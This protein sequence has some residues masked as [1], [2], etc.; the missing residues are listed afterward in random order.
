MVSPV[1]S[2]ILI[3]VGVVMLIGVGVLAAVC[4]LLLWQAWALVRV[5]RMVA[6]SLAAL[7]KP[8]SEIGVKIEGLGAVVTEL[9]GFEDGQFKL[10]EKLIKAVITLDRTVEELQSLL[11]APAEVGAPRRARR[12]TSDVQVGSEATEIDYEQRRKAS[13]DGLISG[14]DLDQF[15]K[16]IATV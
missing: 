7:V 9:K 4:G 16:N 14:E 11:I 5:N 12:K 6:E 3:I 2:V 1:Y 10:I 8:T 13:S 15:G